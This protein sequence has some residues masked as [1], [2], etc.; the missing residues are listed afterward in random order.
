LSHTLD[1][2]LY[3]LPLTLKTYLPDDWS[4]I[5]L[6]QGDNRLKAEVKSDSAGTYVTYQAV[7]NSDPIVISK[8]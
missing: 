2:N 4:E 8:R 5:N 1:K 6:D 7:P 3:D